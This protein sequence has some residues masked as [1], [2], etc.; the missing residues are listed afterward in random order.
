[1]L[2]AAYATGLRSRLAPDGGSHDYN[3]HEHNEGNGEEE[4]G[5]EEE[6]GE[7]PDGLHERAAR[8]ARDKMETMAHPAALLLGAG[9]CSQ[10][11]CCG[12]AVAVCYHT[13]GNGAV[14]C[15]L[16]DAEIHRTVRCQQRF[17]LVCVDSARGA[18][19]G[20]IASPERAPEGD[21]E[22]PEYDSLGDFARAPLGASRSSEGAP[23]G[24]RAESPSSARAESP[25]SARA[26]SPSSA[27]AESPSGARVESPS[28]TQAESSSG[29][30]AEALESAVSL[31]ACLQRYPRFRPI[32][33]TAAALQYRIVAAQAC[34]VADAAEEK[35]DSIGV[36]T[37]PPAE[38]REGFT[39][40]VCAVSKSCMWW[41]V[42]LRGGRPISPLGTQGSPPA[43]LPT[44]ST[45]RLRA[46]YNSF[47]YAS[48]LSPNPTAALNLISY[49]PNLFRSRFSPHS[50]QWRPP[51]LP[52]WRVSC[53]PLHQTST[54]TLC[55]GSS[56]MRVTLFVR[57][58]PWFLY[59]PHGFYTAPMPYL[60]A[61]AGT[62]NGVGPCIGH[63]TD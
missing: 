38:I 10:P 28:G 56:W 44:G 32:V 37:E 13:C 42:R 40:C 12:V 20:G 21:R 55:T 26:E 3:T 48:L 25:S 58:C 8:Y 7:T 1:M 49:R 62:A 24:A 52:Q 22:A 61:A 2:E 19:H 16:H 47:F 17:V 6:S 23:S 27:R 11:S 29:S 9:L 43:L 45:A 57:L 18:G 5:G 14:W 34:A 63:S 35:A 15:T 60:R 50:P 39:R 51:L 41:C 59:R 54:C 4:G 30:L 36:E 46:L 53:A 31:R 33:P